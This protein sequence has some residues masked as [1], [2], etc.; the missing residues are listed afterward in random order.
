M[1]AV[2]PILNSVSV[3]L[4]LLGQSIPPIDPVSPDATIRFEDQSTSL[5][6]VVQEKINHFAEQMLRF[7]IT[8]I[9]T[10]II[11]EGSSQHLGSKAG[12]RAKVVTAALKRRGITSIARA[13]A[14]FG[15]P[16]RLSGRLC[17]S[18]DRAQ[19]HLANTVDWLTR[20]EQ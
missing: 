12:K 6:L 9:S 5:A 10:V 15:E 13:N 19:A 1:L 14:T 3:A 7:Y 4:L 8:E 11:C 16:L 17:H 18:P 2:S 20:A